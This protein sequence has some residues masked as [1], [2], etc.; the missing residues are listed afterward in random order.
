MNRRLLWDIAKLAIVV[1]VFAALYKAGKIDIDTLRLA[2]ARPALVL[3]AAF[4]VFTAIVFTVERWRRL[5]WAVDVHIG[6]G[7]AFTLTL[8]G[9]F[10]SH[11]LPGSVGGDIVKAYYLA[12]GQ[13][14]R[15]ALVATVVF[16]RLLGL[17]T[18]ILMATLAG[19]VVWAYVW[20]SG[21]PPQW[22]SGGV[23]ALIGFV[24]ALFTAFTVGGALFMSDSMSRTRFMKK[25]M[26][27]APFREKTEKIYSA[28]RK[29]GDNPAVAF[30]ALGISFFGQFFLYGAIWILAMA[31]ELNELTVPQFLFVIP[32]C[33][34]INAIPAAPGGLGVGEIG[35]GA[36][37][38]L[39]GYG[40]GVELAVMYHAVSIAISVA[41]GGVIYLVYSS[42]GG[43]TVTLK[44]LEDERGE[45]PA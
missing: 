42:R 23:Q 41:L 6:F 45:G 31:L 8:I 35:F 15:A 40:K 3:T 43:G 16:D 11:A 7:S 10:F 27:M 2:T 24:F 4:L 13:S 28:A 34:L 37:F 20:F 44:R 19:A 21:Y 17:Y 32:V 18:M 25:V 9:M 29:F 22:W 39:F 5:L 12:K 30:T 36:V 1:G 33:I 38:A 14:Q 26:E